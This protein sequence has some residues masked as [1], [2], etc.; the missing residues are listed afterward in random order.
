VGVLAGGRWLL[1]GSPTKNGLDIVLPV[2][3]G[4]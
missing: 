2:P 1:P 3:P 4:L